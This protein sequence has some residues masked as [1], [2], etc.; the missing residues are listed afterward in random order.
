VKTGRLDKQF[1]QDINWL[2]ELRNIGDYGEIRH[3]P[4]A[5]AEKAIAAAERFLNQI[6]T[7]LNK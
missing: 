7:L 4:Q 5:E 3:V 6:K 1:G 2:C